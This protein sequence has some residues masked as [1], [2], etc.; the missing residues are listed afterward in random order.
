[1]KRFP[2]L[3]LFA[4]VFAVAYACTDS[5]APAT[6]HPLLSAKDPTAFLLGDPPPPPVD[7]AINITISSTPFTGSFNGAYFA[8]GTSIESAVAAQAV[9]DE[10]LTFLG[11]AWLRLNNVQP[12]Q[13]GTTASANA[14][15]QR[16]DQK[17]FGM[18]TL[19]IQGH[20]VRIDQVTSFLANPS[21]GATGDLCAHIEFNA[22]IL[23]EFGIFESGHTGTVDAFNIAACNFDGIYFCGGD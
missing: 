11:T 21:C 23:N 13:L 19:V 4:L 18:G 5:T 20:T 17:L 16:T 15:F 7:A 14:R 1:M 8:N 6:S 22:S 3:P 12:D 2:L 10:S 9:G